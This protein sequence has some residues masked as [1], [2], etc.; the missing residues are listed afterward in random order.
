MITREHLDIPP[1]RQTL[2]SRIRDAMR[3]ELREIAFGMFLDRGFDAVSVEQIAEAAGVSQRTFFRYFATKEEVLLEWMDH[4]GPAITASIVAAPA[5]LSPYS[6]VRLAFVEAAGRSEADPQER[7][8][9]RLV[10]QLARTSPRLRAGLAE[11]SRIWEFDIAAA[12]GAR[13]AVDPVLDP[14]P[15]LIAALTLCA[16]T[17]AQTWHLE[18]SEGEAGQ[19]MADIFATLERCFTE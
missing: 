14:R 8:R 17:T 5:G 15:R 10:L 18:R 3:T 2:R 6:A 1:P 9:N 4:F 7:R 12:L 19:D 11:R 13:M 16:A